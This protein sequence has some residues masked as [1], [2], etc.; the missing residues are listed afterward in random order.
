MWHFNAPSVRPY[1]ET[2]KDSLRISF[3][4]IK[5]A[6]QDFKIQIGKGSFGD[7]FKG[8]ISSANGHIPI[9]VKR[10][11]QRR[12]QGEK[13]F[14]TELQVLYEYKHENIIGLIG[15]CN[16]ND[17]KIL[18]Y[19]YAAKG[20]LDRHLKD[21]RLT[22]MERLKIA[23]DVAIGLDFL[24]GADPPA[25]HR[26]IK[27]SNILLN[28]DWETKI[29][30]FGLSMITSVND[31]FDYDVD[32]ACG[33]PGYVDPLF[34]NTGFLTRKSD[35]YSLGVVLLEMMCGRIQDTRKNLVDFVKFHCEEGKVDELV[36]EGVEDKIVFNDLKDK[37]M[38]RS[39][40][41]FLKLAYECLSDEKDKRPTASKVVLHLKKALEFQVNDL[42]E[43]FTKGILLR[44][45]KMCQLSS[46]G[47]RN[48]MVS[49]TMF[50]YEKYIQHRQRSSQKS[51]F[52][53]VVK[54]EDTSNLRIK[55]NIK[56]QF[57]SP[58][59]IYGAHLVFKFCD[60]RKSS[61]ELMYVNLKYQMGSE[62]RYAYFATR[63]D[64]EWMMIELCRFIPHK[65]DVAFEVLIESLSRYY[66][67]RGAIYVEGI[68]FLAINEATL[69]VK[70]PEV[71]QKLK[72][73][74]SVVNSNSNST[75][76]VPDDYHE[77]TKLHD[78]EKVTYSKK[79]LL[80]K[81]Y[82]GNICH[83]LPAKTILYESTDVKR[84]NWISLAE[85]RFVEV[86]E[87]LSHQVFRIKC[88]IETQELLPN[89]NY[90]CHL[91]F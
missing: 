83:M 82:L 69:K 65:K 76:Q 47:E 80:L 49:A 81:S 74:Q 34:L 1:H 51:R 11:D 71:Y 16:E 8:E 23:I 67:G 79:F 25:I 57:L 48:E 15:Y 37:I 35:I 43:M 58:N 4:G 53:R 60:Q 40:I 75:Q 22:W 52:Q 59:V 91:D 21:S 36:F 72:E 66:C 14:L 39:L 2:H 30:D 13:E 3:E 32:Y 24:H 17:E 18:V 26:D 54:M 50:S 87:V 73:V 29:T 31:E 77:M 88:K 41:T 42:N 12:G 70:Q 62:T 20:S 89:T 33:T 63:R 44:K 68:H 5:L 19:E 9:A 85:S 7:V 64:D 38:P 78:G 27:S 84:F 46:E 45:G 10:H 55:I 86:A 90:S 61:G 28:E 56:T 6:T